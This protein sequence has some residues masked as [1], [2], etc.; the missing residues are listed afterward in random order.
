MEKE[1]GW[2]GKYNQ[3]WLQ[4]ASVAAGLAAHQIPFL[5]LF[6]KCN[7]CLGKQLYQNLYFQALLQ[8]DGATWQG[9]FSE[10]WQEWHALLLSR[11]L[12]R[13]ACLLLASPRPTPGPDPLQ[14][15]GQGQQWLELQDGASLCLWITLRKTAIQGPGAPI[16]GFSVEEKDFPVFKSIC[17]HSLAWQSALRGPLEGT[18]TTAWQVFTWPHLLAPK[19]KF[20]S[21]VISWRCKRMT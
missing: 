17:H 20:C 6:L 9:P 16:P 4:K 3:V 2:R 11:A 5:L 12:T 8:V 10:C 18:D 13:E 1:C 21:D 19:N 15:L 7:L 14:R